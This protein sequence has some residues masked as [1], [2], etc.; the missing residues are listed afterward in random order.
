MKDEKNIDRENMTLLAI[1]NLNLFYKLFF[2]S[3]L[4]LFE[5]FLVRLFKPKL[6]KRFYKYI[7]IFYAL[8][9]SYCFH[10][11]LK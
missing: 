9:I 6:Y 10:E 8:V 3:L 5:S 11:V 4:G 7:A 2:M 1:K